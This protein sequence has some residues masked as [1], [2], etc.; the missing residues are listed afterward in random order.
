MPKVIKA[1]LSVDV[2]IGSGSRHETYLVTDDAQT[3][4]ILFY[5]DII[6]FR[7]GFW[8]DPFEIEVAS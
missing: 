4:M 3:L 2:C 8:L 5:K 7:Q 1:V 6:E